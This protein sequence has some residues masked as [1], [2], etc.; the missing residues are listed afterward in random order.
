MNSRFKNYW[1]KRREDRQRREQTMRFV[2]AFERAKEQ[3]ARLTPKH[4]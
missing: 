1:L 3:L 4:P 2:A